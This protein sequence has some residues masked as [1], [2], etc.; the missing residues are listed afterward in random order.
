MT[1]LTNTIMTTKGNA[2]AATTILTNTITRN[3]AAATTILT[4]MIIMNMGPGRRRP[5]RGNR[6]F[7]YW[8][9]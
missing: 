1:I 8:K 7:R 5:D 3:V 9:I 2:A 6:R 4:N